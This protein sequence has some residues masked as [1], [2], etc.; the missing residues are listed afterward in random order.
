MY[1]ATFHAS[2]KPQVV[3]HKDLHMLIHFLD[4]LHPS[5]AV[6]VERQKGDR[7][8]PFGQGWEGHVAA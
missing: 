4:S 5:I 6:Q 7:W 3:Y 8:L 1:R 2:G